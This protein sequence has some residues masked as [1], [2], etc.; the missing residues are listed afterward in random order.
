M[1]NPL[2]LLLLLTA[3]S[4]SPSPAPS[5]D[6][7]EGTAGSSPGPSVSCVFLTPPRVVQ[8]QPASFLQYWEEPDRAE[9]WE[10]GLP[11]APSL[12][13]FRDRIA[14]ELDVDPR[15]LLE[16]QLPQVTGG[17]AEN[18]R[19]VLAGAAGMIRPMN[20]LEGLLLAAQTDRSVARGT[21]MYEDPTEFVGYVLRRGGALKVWFYTVDMAGV[22]G[23]GTLHDP[24]AADL[25]AGWE[26]VMNIHNHNFFPGAE[27]VLGG[28]VPS[29]TDVQLFQNMGPSLGL[30]RGSITNGFDSIEMD[31]GDL[32]RFSGG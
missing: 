8:D 27:M 16:R 12:H 11:D 23:L 30:T 10:A 25:A 19:L 4:P 31:A 21:T 3:C 18:V 22:R 24:V 5:L 9:L 6:G 7:V 20:C 13:A 26:M 28:V 32:E 2:P 15:V 29:A 1:R 14:A 17:D